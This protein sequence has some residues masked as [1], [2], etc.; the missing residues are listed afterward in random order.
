MS[1]PVWLRKL[2]QNL[3]YW[4]QTY[5]HT[6]TLDLNLGLGRLQV[7]VSCFLLFR[8][9]VRS[10]PLAL[11]RDRVEEVVATFTILQPAQNEDSCVSKT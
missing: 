1:L 2:L 5:R 9:H 10:L 8:Y 11:I 7:G 3:F 4:R 6:S